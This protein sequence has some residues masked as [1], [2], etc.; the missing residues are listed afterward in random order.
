MSLLSFFKKLIPCLNKKKDKEIPTA[1]FY[2]EDDSNED[3][4]ILL[5]KLNDK[6]EKRNPLMSIF[7]KLPSPK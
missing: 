2:I 4:Q 1:S 6:I 3:I 7:K 5:D